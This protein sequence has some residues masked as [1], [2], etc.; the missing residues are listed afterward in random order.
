MCP[1]LLRPHHY[2]GGGAPK[3]RERERERER[4]SLIQ[5]SITF[6]SL[7]RALGAEKTFLHCKSIYDFINACYFICVQNAG[8][9]IVKLSR[10][11]F[12]INY[13]CKLP[14]MILCCMWKYD[15]TRFEQFSANSA[16]LKSVCFVYKKHIC[17]F[18]SWY[19][20]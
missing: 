12:N 2:S 7:E 10:T 1:P 8:H 6:L 11:Q 17:V 14:A 20:N 15:A 4:E 19:H 9:C 16:K 18:F 13:L 3:E 5:L